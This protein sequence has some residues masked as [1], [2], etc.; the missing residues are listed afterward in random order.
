MEILLFVVLNLSPIVVQ[1][2][3]QSMSKV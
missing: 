3:C 2:D 1:E